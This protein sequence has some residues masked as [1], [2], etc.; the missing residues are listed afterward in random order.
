MSRFLSSSLLPSFALTVLVA[1]GGSLSACAE[2]A[3]PTNTNPPP[4]APSETSPPKQRPAPTEEP[5]P[6]P[7]PPAPVNEVRVLNLGNVEANREITFDVPEGALGF[8]I[9]VSGAEDIDVALGIKTITS[10]AGEVVHEDFMPK[11]GTHETSDV[12]SI[13]ASASVP[14]SDA[15]TSANP[16]KSG[17]WSFVFASSRGTQFPLTANATVRVQMGAPKTGE[18]LGGRLDLVVYVPPQLKIGKRA[19][20]NAEAA[21]TDE[22]INDRL[23]VFFESFENLFGIQRGDVT[24]V[25][26]SRDL[27]FVDSDEKL[28]EAFT[29][30]TGRTDGAQ[31][32]HVVL[33]NGISISGGQAW[34]ITSG[35]PG[36]A[37]RTGTP[38]S[39]IVVAIGDTPMVGDGTTMAHEAGHFFGLNHTTEFYEGYADP[40]SDTPR[41]EG[42][43]I[44]DPQ[45]I[46]A[47]P[48]RG[49]MM[50]PTSLNP[51]SRSIKASEG[52]K[53][54]V[55]GSPIYKSYAAP[56]PKAD[57]TM[58]H[59]IRSASDVSMTK[60][61]RALNPTEELLVASLCP[62]TAHGRPEALFVRD[63]AAKARL[64]KAQTDPDLP[65]MVRRQA[66]TV[67]G[68]LGSD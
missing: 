63:P 32:L 53:R 15:T 20:A 13:L 9:V 25:P 51:N 42:L 66:A 27:V 6:P 47:C 36:A 39:G 2:D 60:S 46:A 19:I 45:T 37:N 57:K 56:R 62:A 50:F 22:D 18:F 58:S 31:A 17:K 26:A 3:A 54:V 64:Q 21:K 59:R 40:I 33:T 10:P 65:M 68:R 41:C 52:Q 49:N 11:G 14:Q 67:L 1:A 12:R 48:D 35:I 24:F 34:G 5:P 8:N 4:A 43:S 30:S 29:I 7:P 44:E 28:F 16:P 55:R 23:E 61:G 38:M